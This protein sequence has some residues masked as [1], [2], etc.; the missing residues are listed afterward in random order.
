MNDPSALALVER[1][2]RLVHGH[3]EPYFFV[4]HLERI[5]LQTPYPEMARGVRLRL[6]H[7]PERS[8][9]IID[10][11]GVGRP[12]VDEFREAWGGYDPL[13]HQRITLPGKPSIVALT[14]TNADQPRSEQWDE[15][16]VPKRVLIMQLIVTLQQRRLDVAAELGEFMT[17]IKE[18]QN[19]QWKVGA[20]KV[21]DLYGQ[22]RAGAHDDLLLAVAIAVWW[23]DKY[24][25]RTLP[26]R[27]GQQQQYEA[28]GN[29]LVRP[30]QGNGQYVG[31]SNP[32]V[33][34]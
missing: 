9:L 6:G 32:L 30:S 14:I 27:Q 4:G 18:A 24:A 2:M 5:P 19:F 10:A 31:V 28:I 15:W 13:T 8:A 12:V 20:N 33:R 16:Y 34:G 25:P 11:T 17:W 7:I 1:E 22:W 26:Q 23:G 29:P 3:L 21:D